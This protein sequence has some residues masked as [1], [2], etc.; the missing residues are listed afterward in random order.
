MRTWI[1]SAV[2]VRLVLIIDNVSKKE[3]KG[4]KALGLREGRL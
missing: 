2:A 1:P 3:T 4:R